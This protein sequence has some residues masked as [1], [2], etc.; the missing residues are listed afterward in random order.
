M[1]TM[2]GRGAEVAR[3][4]A[5]IDDAGAAGGAMIVRGDAGIGKSTLLRAAIDHARNRDYLLLSTIGTPAEQHLPFASLHHLLGPALGTAAKLA[6][7]QRAALNHV[8][9]LTAAES[10]QSPFVVALAALELLAEHAAEG[11]LLV[12]VDD[13]QWLDEASLDVLMFVARRVQNERI[14]LVL[15]T[16]EPEIGEGAEPN[17]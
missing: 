10:P 11:P 5:L 4:L 1:L 3:V 7:P 9:G 14:V 13:A 12:A 17:C 16:R 8:F 15:A 2:V 6:P